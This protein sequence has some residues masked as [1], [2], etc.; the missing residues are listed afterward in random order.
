MNALTKAN[1][2]TGQVVAHPANSD[3]FLAMISHAASDPNFDIEKMRQLVGIRNEELARQARVAFDSA[4]AEMQ[5]KLPVIDRNGR[6]EI[7]KKDKDGERNG[8][9]QQSSAYALWADIKDACNPFMLEHGFGISFRPKTTADGKI[10]VTCILS[11]R[12]GH[13]EESDSIPMQHDS[14]G[15]KNA[16]QAVGSSLSYGTR[17]MG[18]MMLGVV[19]KENDDD[20]RG[21]ASPQYVT[22]DQVREI[23]ILLGHTQ[24]DKDA[25]L[26]F[27]KSE[28]LETMQ[29][30]TGV[31][32]VAWLKAKRERMGAAK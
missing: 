29:R 4:F 10:V 30:E 23:E 25:F 2:Q 3:P 9:V 17:Y 18:I 20:G 26:K 32:A 12:D 1:E 5:P 27:F 28:N 7:R 14:T 19:T 15:S 21:A 8:D 6:I 31:S 22:E 11:H 13:R 24:S 16:V